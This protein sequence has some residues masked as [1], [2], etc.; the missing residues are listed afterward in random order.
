[1]LGGRGAA[2]CAALLTGRAE[3]VR[4]GLAMARRMLVLRAIGVD[5]PA[6]GALGKARDCV[7]DHIPPRGP[8]AWGESTMYSDIVLQA[9]SM[10]K[11]ATVSSVEGRGF[12]TDRMHPYEKRI[13]GKDLWWASVR[14]FYRS[15]SATERRTKGVIGIAP[16][17][18]DRTTE[19]EA[20]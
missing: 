3:N 17:R 5:F 12:T 9:S 1:M 2:Q 7:D 4:E 6:P 8:N 11:F 16:G 14:N 18:L 10:C 19:S 13:S 20:A 15:A